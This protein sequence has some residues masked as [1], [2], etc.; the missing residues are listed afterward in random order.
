M[1]NAGAKKTINKVNFKEKEVYLDKALRPVDKANCAFTI[2]FHYSETGDIL[3]KITFTP[4]SSTSF[5]AFCIDE[6][7]INRYSGL[8][9]P[10]DNFMNILRKRSLENLV[11]LKKYVFECQKFI[12]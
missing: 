1:A 10:D 5:K 8:K 12:N 2:K 7:I 3:K 6:D 9:R 11:S 4:T